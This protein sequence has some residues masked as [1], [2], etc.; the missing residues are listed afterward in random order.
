[1][2]F[3]LLRTQDD[4][5]SRPNSSFLQDA[6]CQNHKLRLPHKG[7]C[8]EWR[9]LLL[10]PT[11]AGLWR[12]ILRSIRISKFY[13]RP[14]FTWSSEVHELWCA[15]EKV[16]FY[17]HTACISKFR[18]CKVNLSL[19]GFWHPFHLSHLKLLETSACFSGLFQV[20]DT[21][22]PFHLNCRGIISRCGS[23]NIKAE[24]SKITRKQAHFCWRHLDATK[25]LKGHVPSCVNIKMI[26]FWL[27][28]NSRFFISFVSLLQIHR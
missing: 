19:F 10:F 16:W 14:W 23:V 6:R 13:L 26:S 18:R 15:A 27:F 24:E 1:M 2:L 21:K 8:N 9:L 4:C 17:N 20:G 7:L 28:L 11:S 3:V 12:K 22:Y 25:K 5:R